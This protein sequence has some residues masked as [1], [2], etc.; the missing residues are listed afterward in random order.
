MMSPRFDPDAEYDPFIPGRLPNVRY[1]ADPTIR[2]RGRK[3]RVWIDSGDSIVAPRTAGIDGKRG[4][5]GGQGEPLG[6]VDSRPSRFCLLVI[7]VAQKQSF[8]S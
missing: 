8:T 4:V 3:G 1:L 6:R 5:Q 7:P 2:R